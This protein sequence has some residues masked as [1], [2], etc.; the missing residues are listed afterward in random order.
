[1]AAAPF[2][3]RYVREIV[4]VFVLIAIALFVAGIFLMGRAQRWFEHEVEL[5]TIFPPEG[6][7]G[8]Q[9]GTRIEILG[10][11]AGRVE[12]VSV[13]PDGSIEGRLRI[14]S[15][16]ARFLHVDSEAVV[17]KEY[18]VAG[19]AF[20]V[21]TTGSG[22]PLT[23]ETAT[24]PIRK[25]TE[26]LEIVQLV[27]EQI[28]ESVLPVLKEVEATLAEYRGLAADL[29]HPDHT[30]QQ[31]L[32]NLN[33]IAAGLREGEGTAGRLLRD[34]AI[35][36]ETRGAIAQIRSLLAEAEAAMGEVRTILR[37]VQTASASLPPM[38]DTVRAELKDVPGLVLQTRATLNETEKLLTGLQHH[39]LLRGAMRPDGSI[40]AIPAAA[41]A[42]PD[43]GQP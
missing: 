14:R 22:P 28:Q 3:F 16:Y 10:T 6:T 41:V 39:W 15:D 5:R 38:M 19:A 12:S 20:I 4:G 35:A 17:K 18:G 13:Q 37:N 26:L 42:A 34:P 9:R 24:I 33:A 31:L 23:A 8:V 30:L 21:L 40:E 36:D 7:F 27:V 32:A 11:T 1:M 25:D 29:R 2:K 43:G